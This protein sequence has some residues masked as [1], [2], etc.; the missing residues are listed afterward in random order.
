M[1]WYSQVVD[2]GQG[3]QRLS[4]GARVA[5]EPGIPCWGSKMARFAQITPNFKQSALGPSLCLSCWN[6]KRAGLLL[7]GGRPINASDIS[8]SILAMQGTV[9]PS[10]NNL[11]SCFHRAGRYNLDPDVRFFATPPVHGSLAK[12]VDHP[13]DFCFP[14]P[15]K[16][17]YEEGAMIEP[18]SNGIHACKR[19]GVAPGKTVAILGAGPMGKLLVPGAIK[20]CSMP[21]LGFGQ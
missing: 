14:L 7:L 17:S 9:K 6:V 1:R 8:P 11:L 15:D 20:S 12:Y 19:A 5:L 13:E 10:I 16:L 4:A 21:Q 2:V 3:V 18:L